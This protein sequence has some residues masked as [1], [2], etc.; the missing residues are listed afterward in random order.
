MQQTR[1]AAAARG[2]GGDRQLFPLK[3]GATVYGAVISGE[4]LFYVR[5]KGRPER[6]DGQ[7]SFLQLW[8]LKNGTWRMAR[9]LSYDHGLVRESR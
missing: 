8:L 4:H 9:I 2:R 6:A 1:L 5:E 3:D 7:A